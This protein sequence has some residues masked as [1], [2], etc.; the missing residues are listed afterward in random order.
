MSEKSSSSLII[1]NKPDDIGEKRLQIPG[2][3]NAVIGGLAYLNDTHIYDASDYSGAFHDFIICNDGNKMTSSR[4]LTRL[5]VFLGRYLIRERHIEGAWPGFI[6]YVPEFTNPYLKAFSIVTDYNLYTIA[7]TAYSLFLFDDSNL[8]ED[9]RFVKSMLNNANA[10]IR[11]YRRGNAYNFWLPFVDTRRD[12]I[13]TRPVNLPVSIIDLRFMIYKLSGLLGL[14]KFK[15]SEAILNWVENC[16]DKNKNPWGS[17]A[18][19]N[20]PNDADNTSVAIAT[21]ILYN[22]IFPENQEYEDLSPLDKIPFFRDSNR[23]KYD[24][25]NQPDEN[26]TGAFMTWFKDEELPVFSSPENGVIN[27]PI[28]PCTGN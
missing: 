13:F 18:I 3:Q 23:S 24:T 17:N 8:P 6:H 9:L 16:Y 27:F 22:K 20:L 15:G 5:R 12:Y 4:I 21:H 19:F 28:P 1:N 11:K 2:L 26:D 10:A 14:K 7:S 25:N